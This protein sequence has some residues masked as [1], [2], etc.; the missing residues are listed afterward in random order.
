MAANDRTWGNP[1]MR[2]TGRNLAAAKPAAIRLKPVR[3]QARNVRSLARWV[4]PGYPGR[5]RLPPFCRLHKL[6]AACWFDSDRPHDGITDRVGPIDSGAAHGGRN[7]PA[8]PP[9][10]RHARSAARWLRIAHACVKFVHLQFSRPEIWTP[11]A[12]SAS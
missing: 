10:A 7:V 4:Q 3:S 1:G 9:K 12:P 6:V 2:S 11:D 8:A 5:R